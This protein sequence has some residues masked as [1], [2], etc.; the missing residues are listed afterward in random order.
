MQTYIRQTGELK[1]NEQTAEKLQKDI[2]GLEET[3]KTLTAEQTRKAEAEAEKA[4]NSETETSGDASG[5]N[6]RTD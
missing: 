2:S 4:Q 1:K 5:G 6:R 3:V